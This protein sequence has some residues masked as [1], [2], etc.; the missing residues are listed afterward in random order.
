M[1]WV[2]DAEF[3]KMRDTL[4]VSIPQSASKFMT[5]HR[6]ADNITENFYETLNYCPS[7]INI[8]KCYGNKLFSIRHFTGYHSS[9]IGSE[10]VLPLMKEQLKIIKKQESLHPDISYYYDNMSLYF[11]KNSVSDKVI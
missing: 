8:T 1:F 11:C 10:H 4:N 3:E 5:G 2:D 7:S 6:L 9:K